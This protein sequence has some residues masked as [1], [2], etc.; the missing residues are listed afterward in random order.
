M[1][2]KKIH[3]CIL[4]ID[5]G[6]TGATVLVI[7]GNG[8]VFGRAYSEFRQFYPRPGWVEHDPEEIWRT[9]VEV[10][11]KAIADVP[12]EA[13][14]AVGITNQRETTVVWDAETGKPVYNAI[15]WQCR[16]TADLCNKL[17]ADGHEET[18]RSKTGLVVDAYFSGTKIRWI[19]DNV[20]GA[21]KRAEEGKLRFGNIDTWLIWKLTGGREHLT[22]Y[23]NASRTMLYNIGRRQWDA[24][25]MDILKVPES[26]LP[27]VRSSSGDFG[28]CEKDI[29]GIEAPI[30]GVAGDQQ[31]ALFGQL[32][33]RPGSCKNTYGTGCF[34]LSPTPERVHS[35]HGLITTLA[36]DARGGPTYAIEGSVFIAG[37]VVQWL[38]DEMGLIDQAPD[39]EYFASKAPDTGGVYIVPAFVGLGAPHWNMEARGT[40]TG[41]TRGTNKN[42][43]IR[44]ALESI[45]YQSADLVKSIDGDLGKRAEE[46]RVDGGACLNDLL[47]QFQADILGIPVNRPAMVETTAL[48]SAFLAG[49]KVGLWSDSGELA[50]VRK[51]DKIFEPSMSEARREELLEG[52]SDAVK[53][54]LSGTEND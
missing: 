10:L 52:W 47:M 50:E 41:I 37:A 13:I 20:K 23:S 14:K 49:L 18:I 48:G 1:A 39:S 19:L 24:E 54:A 33:T 31:A 21:R 12:P 7:D 43:I 38:R 40:I 45:A 8:E 4:A 22:D 36:C 16:R 15:V 28:K 9:T 51:T 29:I 6:T 42:H 5:Q 30:A 2:S 25:L 46:L 17:K 53:Q 27:Q 26:M 34:A 11:N 32:C 35:Q 44:A 3:E